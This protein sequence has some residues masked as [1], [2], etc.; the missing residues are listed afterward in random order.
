MCVMSVAA[1]GRNGAATLKLA[2]FAVHMQ[3]APRAKMTQNFQQ[4]G[5]VV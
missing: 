1:H 5:V 4:N 2:E 3:R